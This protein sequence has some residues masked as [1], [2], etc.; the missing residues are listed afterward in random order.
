[1][2][3]SG[4]SIH[5]DARKIGTEELSQSDDSLMI[6]RIFNGIQISWNAL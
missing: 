2:V 6:F 5:T 4:F 3:L 1:M